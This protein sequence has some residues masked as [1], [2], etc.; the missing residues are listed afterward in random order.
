VLEPFDDLRAH[1]ARIQRPS[2]DDVPTSFE[3]LRGADKPEVK[4]RTFHVF[5]SAR[6]GPRVLL[7]ASTGRND[8]KPDACTG[9]EIDRGHVC[10]RRRR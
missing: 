1:R 10:L 5:S 6:F 7:G 9:G 4:Q 2:L 3:S 8:A